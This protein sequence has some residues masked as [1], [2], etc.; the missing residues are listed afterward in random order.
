[1]RLSIKT[2]NSHTG[3]LLGV[4]L[5]CTIFF[6]TN[7]SAFKS[8]VCVKFEPSCEETPYDMAEGDRYLTSYQRQLNHRNV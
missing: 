5:L 7:S 1:V 3:N 8:G 2:F 4:N 6:L